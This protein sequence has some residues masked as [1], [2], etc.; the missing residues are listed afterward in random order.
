MSI[1]WKQN[2]VWIR[3]H[4]ADERISSLYGFDLIAKSETA[5][6]DGFDVILKRFFVKGERDILYNYNHGLGTESLPDYA[7]ICFF[8]RIKINVK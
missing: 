6:K 7:R 2:H 5:G 4:R 3:A 1:I 8:T